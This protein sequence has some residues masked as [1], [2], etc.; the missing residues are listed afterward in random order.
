MHSDT[1]TVASNDYEQI[2]EIPLGC[3]FARCGCM[4][5]TCATEDLLKV[6]CVNCELS[7][8]KGTQQDLD[9]MGS[10]I[11]LV[12]LKE[13]IHEQKNDG[14]KSKREMGRSAD[15]GTRLFEHDI[16]PDR[17]NPSNG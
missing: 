9:M 5:W 10:K 14:K 4:W 3:S 2:L 12:Y 15:D 8:M 11:K 1:G 17:R 7:L 6:S 13:S 16:E